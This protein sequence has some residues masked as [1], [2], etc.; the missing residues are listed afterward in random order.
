MPLYPHPLSPGYWRS[1]AGELKDLRRLVFMALMIAACIVLS[2]CSIRLGES[3]SLS[4]TFLARALCSL[5][6][7]PLAVIVFGAAEDTLSFFLSSGVYPYF[8]GYMLTTIT[9]CMI[10][11]LFFY[12]AKITWRRIILA[13]LLTNIQNVLLGALWSAILYSKGYLYYLT[14]S[15]VKNALY[16]PANSAAGLPVSGGAAGDAAATLAPGAAAGRPPA[17]VSDVFTNN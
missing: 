2:H 13:K 4:I 3:L 14:Q 6:C 5:V 17:L 16:L 15:A 8:P 7:G 10:Y 1:A 12:R 9:G 11:A